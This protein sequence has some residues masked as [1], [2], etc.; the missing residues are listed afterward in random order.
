MSAWTNFITPAARYTVTQPAVH[1]EIDTTYRLPL[2]NRCSE[3]CFCSKHLHC[4]SY[5]VSTEVAGSPLRSA[6][7]A[8]ISKNLPS[9]TV[10]SR[11]PNLEGV[12][13]GSKHSKNRQRKQKKEKGGRNKET[14]A[15][16][17]CGRGRHAACCCQEEAGTPS[18]DLHHL[19]QWWRMLHFQIPCS[20]IASSITFSSNR[21]QLC[22]LN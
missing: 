15:K 20:R 13:Y 12:R 9:Q 18:G 2:L 1:Q 7:R 11:R 14:N 4:G 19:L 3:H 6:R 22:T 8:R 5:L 17:P 16:I 21:L 10:C